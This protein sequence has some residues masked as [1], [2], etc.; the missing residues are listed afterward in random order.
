MESA[1]TQNCVASVTY[2]DIC[3]IKRYFPIPKY[4]FTDH[5]PKQPRTFRFIIF[6]IQPS[7]LESLAKGE[8]PPNFLPL[9]SSLF[10]EDREWEGTHNEVISLLNK[11]YWNISWINENPIWFHEILTPLWN[12][13]FSTSKGLLDTM[14]PLMKCRISDTNYSFIFLLCSGIWYEQMAPKYLPILG[15]AEDFKLIVKWN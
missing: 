1:V 10:S 4:W 11:L 9:L 8:E 12:L 7:L 3:M 2:I 6:F 5:C 13:S 15:E 14:L